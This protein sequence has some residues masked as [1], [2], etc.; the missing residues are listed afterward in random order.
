MLKLITNFARDL[1]E[2]II[3]IG[4]MIAFLPSSIK[5]F[6]IA[7]ISFVIGI[8][9]SVYHRLNYADVPVSEY[10]R[11]QVMVEDNGDVKDL[12]FKLYDDKILSRTDCRKLDDLYEQ[13]TKSEITKGMLSE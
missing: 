2:E 11:I 3:G 12:F 8:P 1:G 5:V 7:M 6:L 9:L 13:N 10:K 4:K